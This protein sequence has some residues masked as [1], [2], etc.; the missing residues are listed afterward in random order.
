M[1]EESVVESNSSVAEQSLVESSVNTSVD[2]I[3]PSTSTASI[4]VETL[5]IRSKSTRPA[6]SQE[7]CE[8][9]VEEFFEGFILRYHTVCYLKKK[10]FWSGVRESKINTDKWQKRFYLF[11][12][13]CNASTK[14]TE[15]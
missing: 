14:I 7:E 4:P 15:T 9:L 2:C 12:M 6:L 8:V 1:L 5:P 3:M 13:H 11:I 10:H